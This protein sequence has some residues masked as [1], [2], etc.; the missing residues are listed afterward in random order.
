MLILIVVLMIVLTLSSDAF[1]TSRNLL[2]ILTQ[3][4]PLAIVAMAGTLVIIA[5]GFDLSTGAMFAVASVSAAWVGLH[6]DPVLGLAHRPARRARRSGSSTASS[7][8]GCAC[9]RS[10]PRWRRASSTAVSPC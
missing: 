6:H 4:A 5:G 10:S 1:L 3:N 2:N 8:P 7:S 9:T